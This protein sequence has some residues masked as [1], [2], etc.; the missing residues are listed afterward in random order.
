MPVRYIVRLTRIDEDGKR[1]YGYV[2]ENGSVSS[3]KKDAHQY[4]DL[5]NAQRIAELL[6][7][8]PWLFGEVREYD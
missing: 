1:R 6:G 3:I 8:A 4:R 5:Y 7:K 2:K